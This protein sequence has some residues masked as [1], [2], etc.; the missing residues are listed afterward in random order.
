MHFQLRVLRALRGNKDRIFMI[1]VRKTHPTAAACSKHCRVRFTHQ[2]QPV[3]FTGNH[4]FV[5][6][7]V[8]IYGAWNAPYGF[9]L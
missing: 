7:T 8:A 9:E 1:S 6:S 2:E 3:I 5:A 4:K